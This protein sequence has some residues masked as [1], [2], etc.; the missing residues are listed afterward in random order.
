MR[1]HRA[2]R[3]GEVCGQ[4]DADVGHDRLRLTRLLAHQAVNRLVLARASA[5][6]AAVLLAGGLARL[7]ALIGN[8]LLPVPMLDA[9][10]E[11]VQHEADRRQHA[12]VRGPGIEILDPW[13]RETREGRAIVT[14]G[15]GEIV[16]LSIVNSEWL[17]GAA[18]VSKI[19]RPPSVEV[20]EVRAVRPDIAVSTD[21]IVGFPGE[22]DAQFDNL[23]GFV[24]EGH[25]DYLGAFTYS[26]E[27][28]SRAAKMPDQV[29]DRTKK[30]R[31]A[32]AMKLQQKIGWM[33]FLSNVGPLEVAFVLV[34]EPVSI[35]T[36]FLTLDDTFA[37]AAVVGD[38][39]HVGIGAIAVT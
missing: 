31:Y 15:F 4:P 17:G 11:Q 19:D 14:L 6:V 1:Q 8:G 30:A 37:I 33:L 16:R 2:A 25:F 20:A 21:I 38:T 13:L 26:Q 7:S 28:G 9:R 32:S 24:K 27:E 3:C 18:G 34:E 5:F 36:V 23:L 39:T 12:A 35:A 10:R 29:S 22:T